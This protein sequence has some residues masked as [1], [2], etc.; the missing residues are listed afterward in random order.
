VLFLLLVSASACTS[1]G[2]GSSSS[3]SSSSSGGAPD[4]GPVPPEAGVDGGVA[5][6][7]FCEEEQKRRDGGGILFCDDFEKNDLAEK[8]PTIVTEIGTVGVEDGA[9]VGRAGGKVLHLVRTKPGSEF[10]NTVGVR[11]FLSLEPIPVRVAYDLRYSEWPLDPAN[12]NWLGSNVDHG[13]LHA[14]LS[15]PNNSRGLQ[16]LLYTGDG[17]Y[18]SAIGQNLTA[19]TNRWEH[20]EVVVVPSDPA[21]VELWVGSDANKAKVA[22]L[23]ETIALPSASPTFAPVILALGLTRS[24]A[25][26]M[27]EVEAFYDNLVVTS[28]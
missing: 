26:P 21:H 19:P 17:I 4:A 20:Y 3:S 25:A 28:P 18:S 7:T 22:Q 11:R 27:P 8:W 1:F 15:L 13:P 14:W 9:S 12:S 10:E 24:N 23:D 5:V 2:V 16:L 6:G